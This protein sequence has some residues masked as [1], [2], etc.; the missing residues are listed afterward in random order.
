MHR[1]TPVDHYVEPNPGYPGQM[2]TVFV[3]EDTPEFQRIRDAF[4]A[5]ELQGSLSHFNDVIRA[6]Q[7]Q[8]RLDKQQIQLDKRAVQHE[9]R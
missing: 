6:I 4:R 5:G 7:A 2:R 3:F 1:I 9:P 8:C